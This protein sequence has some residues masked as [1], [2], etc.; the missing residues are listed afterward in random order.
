MLGILNIYTAS[1]GFVSRDMENLR[2][3]FEKI[4]KPLLFSCRD[5][6][7]RLS[8]IRDLEG[9]LRL[10]LQKGRDFLPLTPLSLEEKRALEDRL[11][12]ME[13]LFTGFDALPASEKEKRILQALDRLS[14]LKMT[15]AE[16]KEGSRPEE[17]EGADPFLPEERE[18]ALA[19]PT[20]SV[21]GVG[22]RTAVLLER[23][24]LKTI[25]DL[26][27]FLPRRYEDRR[28][29]AAMGQLLPGRKE[30]VLGTVTQVRETRYGRT[31]NLEVL[32]TDGTG[33][34][35]ARW[36]KGNF[37]YLRNLIRPGTRLVMTG[38]VRAWFAG[39]DMVHPDFEV[40]DDG[41][42]ETLHFRRIVPVYSE[43]EGLHQKILR[44]I[45]AETLTGFG[46]YLW[47]PIPAGYS[48]GRGV[49]SFRKALESLHYPDG[50]ENIDSYNAFQSEAHRRV[51]YDELFF[52]Q[53][54]MAFRNRGARRESG[55]PFETGGTLV[56]RFVAGLPYA[57]TGDQKRVIAEIDRDL[58]RSWPMHR[59]LQGDVGCGKTVVSMIPMITAC[60]NG[61]QAALMAPTEI[62]A[63]QHHARIAPWA[64]RLGLE[65]GLVTGSR[66]GRIREEVLEKIR[67]GDIHLVVGTHALIQ[68]GVAFRKLG[69]VVI[70]EQ[71]RFGVLQR[72]TL[73]EKGS[74]PHVLVMTAT[75]IPRTLALTVHG[76][77]DLSTIRELPPGREAIRTQI[78]TERN[79]PMLYE[80]IRRAVKTGNQAFIVYPLVE[81]SE[82]LD[83]K[84]ATGMARELQE[85]V[86]PE[87]PV[88]LLHGRM[89][90]REKEEIMAAFQKGE[91]PILVST[92][93][94]EV[95]IDVPTASLM[96]V[97]HAE[98]FGLSQLH[99][100]RG[101]V[102]R[103]GGAAQCL[104]MAGDPLSAVSRKRLKVMAE[105]N[106]GFRIAEE[107]LEI[108]G[109]G[110]FMGTR[111]SGLPDFRVADILRDRALLD[112]AREAA[113]LA[114]DEMEKEPAGRYVILR[115]ELFRRWRERLA[116]AETA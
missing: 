41:E 35:K 79:R 62:L 49:P 92:T 1:T 94:I 55:L 56:R 61:C 69:L 15:V 7:R 48:G 25:E 102:G 4:E 80:R 10:Y 75:P 54:A 63:E 2:D 95:G 115:K 23:K 87:Y 18:R 71:H 106:D 6:F 57:L 103:G 98:R 83:L 64:S 65:A 89:K 100:L 88:G 17:P 53:L 105:T 28:Q 112:E 78:L 42:G 111:Q 20:R 70:D 76:D 8:S 73:R 31:R 113:F 114:A 116:L 12:D 52:F 58:A 101:R 67:R 72:A 104:L 30:T 107:D 91:I 109:P 96:V 74:S 93:V 3:L 34:L 43:T 24:G 86:F 37:A 90:G 39:R 77:L 84:D 44:R 14:G 26:L 45:L 16:K 38:Q 50:S 33:I 60:A 29:V 22:P 51:I 9:T 59:L 81:G 46:K 108:R 66:R 32:L 47:S 27:Y 21:R 82:A 36:L 97:E 68:E 110:E 99:Q 5:R 85:R 13:R 40:L 19:A 11:E